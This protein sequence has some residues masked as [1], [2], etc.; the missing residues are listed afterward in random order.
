M[1]LFQVLIGKVDGIPQE[2]LKEAYDELILYKGWTI[3]DICVVLFHFLTVL[4]I[5]CPILIIT[6]AN[7]LFYS[8]YNLNTPQQTLTIEDF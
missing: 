4:I 2:Q 3:V 8:P 1:T 6:F 7:R 5:G